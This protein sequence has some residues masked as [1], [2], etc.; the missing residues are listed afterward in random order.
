M[1]YAAE[2]ALAALTCVNDDVV[3]EPVKHL[4]MKSAVSFADQPS[5]HV[6]LQCIIQ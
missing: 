5:D 4:I 6:E 3:I 1:R 2:H